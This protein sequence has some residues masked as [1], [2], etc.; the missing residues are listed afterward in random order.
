MPLTEKINISAVIPTCNRKRSLM[1]L[2]DSLDHSIYPILE[3][4]IVDSGDDP[5][6]SEDYAA[7]SR[8]PI[9]YM[10]S[11][12]SVCIQRNLGIR[13]ARTPLIFLCDD[14]MEVPAD[15]LQRLV[16]HLEAHPEAGAVSG[17]VLQKEKGVW[18][19]GY[20]V[21]SASELV[22]KFI[23]QHGIWGEIECPD[24]FLL[25]RIKH[26]YQRKGNHISRAG[27]PVIT[28]F[29]GDYFTTPVYTLCASLV[30]KGLA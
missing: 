27:W 20:P 29:S 1:T 6:V 30:K 16:K 17:L 22:R 24:N 2:L 25:R 26:Y 28:H 19:A 7:F 10:R 3:V 4:I 14:D 15:Y 21:R 23:F 8:L 13:E 9:R 5:L 12:R 18:Q 11:E